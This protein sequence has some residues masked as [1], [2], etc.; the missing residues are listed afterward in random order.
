MHS[1]GR[2]V[3]V[4]LYMHVQAV[5]FLCIKHILKIKCGKYS[6]THHI[7]RCSSEEGEP[8]I[9]RVVSWQ[10]L[11]VRERTTFPTGDD[12]EST[13]QN[14]FP[15]SAMDTLYKVATPTTQW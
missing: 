15:P 4:L 11:P 13:K 9:P 14:T 2:G 6:F 7:R 8:H 10:N 5:V 3:K 1:V 12:L